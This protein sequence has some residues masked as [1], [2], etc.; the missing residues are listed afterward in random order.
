[1]V[2]SSLVSQQPLVFD[3]KTRAIESS[4]EKKLNCKCGTLLLR[5]DSGQSQKV[6]LFTSFQTY[7]YLPQS[8][9]VLHTNMG[10]NRSRY[11][12]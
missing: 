7:V 2:S 4:K 9:A 10:V 11:N 8:V 5:S 12:D 3:F 1:M 6:I